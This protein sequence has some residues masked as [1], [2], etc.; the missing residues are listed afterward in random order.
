MDG[1]L[2]EFW[3]GNL[4]GTNEGKIDD[5]DVIVFDCLSDCKVNRLGVGLSDGLGDGRADT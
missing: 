3:E 5:I 1:T 4:D 2:N